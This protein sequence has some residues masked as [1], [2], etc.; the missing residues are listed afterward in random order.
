MGEAVKMKR[1][2]AWSFKPLTILTRFIV[3]ISLDFKQSKRL[4]GMGF[5][6]LLFGVFILTFNILVNAQRGIE[7][8][9]FSKMKTNVQNFES[10]FLFFKEHPDALLQFVVDCTTIM[11]WVAI[12]LI[13]LVFFFTI[14]FT[15]KWKI[16]TLVLKKIKT[17]MELSV[18][19]FRSC[20][21]SCMAAIFLLALVIYPENVFKI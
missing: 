7:L 4:K 16:L 8:K 19:I 15:R 10:P 2:F 21:K 11:F 5:I 6:V 14:L 12:P 13:Q 20:R 17:R 3:G 9:K 18:K 1:S